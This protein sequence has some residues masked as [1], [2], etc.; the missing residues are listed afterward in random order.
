MGECSQCEVM[1]DVRVFRL[2]AAQKLSTSRQI[3]EELAHFERGAMGSAGFLYFENLAAVNDD[4]RRGRG[5]AA[6]LAGDNAQPADTGD[7]GQG[8]AAKTHRGDGAEIF[9]ALNLAGGMPLEA[10]QCVV[11][12]HAGAIIGHSDEAA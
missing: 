3:E 10:E 6:A 2:F 7:T 11:P 12:V 8:F 9:G 1:M 5:I 4:L